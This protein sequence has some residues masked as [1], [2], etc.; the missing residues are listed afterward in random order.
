MASVVFEADELRS[1]VD[2]A[3]E[4][5]VRRMRDE[6]PQ[7]EVG[8]ILWDKRTAA[9]RIGVS[10]STLDRLRDRGLPCIKVEGKVLF[11]PSSLDAWAAQNE[12]TGG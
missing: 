3:V 5:A 10:V 4:A 8:A 1:V 12:T 9:K 6:Q 7:D 2:M 11:R